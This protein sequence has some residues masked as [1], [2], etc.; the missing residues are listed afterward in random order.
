MA[1]LNS[2]DST[3]DRLAVKEELVKRRT[4]LRRM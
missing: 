2:E 1:V 4:N 3:D